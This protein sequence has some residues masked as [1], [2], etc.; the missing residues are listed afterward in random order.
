MT[1]SIKDVPSIILEEQENTPELVAFLSLESFEHDEDIP[2]YVNVLEGSLI[3]VYKKA[4]TIHENKQYRYLVS[5]CDNPEA[6]VWAREQM[7]PIGF[8][9]YSYARLDEWLGYIEESKGD[10]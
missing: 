9:E 7:G 6:P 3:D 8:D 2:D 1:N 4:L 10:G 5:V